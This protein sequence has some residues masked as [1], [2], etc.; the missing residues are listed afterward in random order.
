MLKAADLSFSEVRRHMAAY[1]RIGYK[2]RTT[3]TIVVPAQNDRGEPWHTVVSRIWLDVRGGQRAFDLTLCA[4]DMATVG[5]D[6]VLLLV[7]VM[8]KG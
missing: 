8:R 5:K 2:T 1:L 3:W 6:R 7:G 4:E